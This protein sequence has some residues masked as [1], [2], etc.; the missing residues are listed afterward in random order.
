ME[1]NAFEYTRAK[2]EDHELDIDFDEDCLAECL[3]A[4]M[5]DVLS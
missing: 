5:S 2:D 1:E 3:E 4:S